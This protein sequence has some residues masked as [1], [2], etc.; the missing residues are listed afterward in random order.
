MH[1]RTRFAVSVQVFV[2]TR[3]KGNAKGDKWRIIVNHE[4]QQVYKSFHTA[5]EA[6]FVRS[7]AVDPKE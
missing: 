1:T 2:H 6:G 5:I 4:T 7:K 3:T